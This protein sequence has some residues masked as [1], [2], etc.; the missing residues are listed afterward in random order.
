MTRIVSVLL[1]LTL[2]KAI[3]G[4]GPRFEVK[5]SEPL[6][7]FVYVEQLSSKKPDNPLKK[8]FLNSH[9]NREKF[10]ALLKQFDTLE[11]NYAYEY[12]Q[13]PYASKIPG[14]TQSFI[15]KCLVASANLKDFKRK[16]VGIIPNSELLHL[17]T[18][19]YEFQQVYRDL[20]YQ[21]AKIKFEKQLKEITEFIQ[22]KNMASYL[23]KGLLFYKS[24]WEESFPFEIALYPLPDTDGFTA[25]AFYNVAICG[26]RTGMKDYN[27]LLSVMFHEIYH[28]LYDEQP[29]QVKRQISKWFS[30]N[31]SKCST[32][33]YLLLNEVLATA[34]GNGYVFESLSSKQDSEDWYDRKYINLMAKK[35]YPLVNEY[36]TQKKS[37]DENFINAY[38]AIYQE[39]FSPWINE[40]DNL[41]CYRYVISDN[42]EDFNTIIQAYPYSSFFQYENEVS[43]KA[44]DKLKGTPITKIIIISKENDQK[45]ALVKKKFPELKDWIYKP[46]KDFLYSTFLA[47]KTHLI[48]INDIKTSTADQLK[49]QIK[50]RAPE[51]KA[52]K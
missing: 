33:S 8:Q 40:L 24:Y 41:M 4:Q 1:C 12:Q 9:Y 43:E 34:M 29:L 45:L 48:I 46:K 42:N 18:I 28:I 30:D 32:Y 27:V 19:L 5:F 13:F 52:V 37:I 7:V 38:I 2:C 16:A 14:L 36:V 23:D 49:G 35:I 51:E 17:S 44:I 26:L 21:P 6:A 10:T 15:K 3:H 25:E 22:T 20:V 39:N 47:D 31:P 11:I 50:V